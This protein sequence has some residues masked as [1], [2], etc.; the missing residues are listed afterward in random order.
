MDESKILAYA[1]SLINKRKYTENSEGDITVAM[2]ARTLRDA[3]KGDSG[4]FYTKLKRIARN[5]TGRTIGIEDPANKAFCFVSLINKTEYEGGVFTIEFSRYIQHYLKDF[6]GPYTWLQLLELLS[7]DSIYS[8]RIAEVLRS[9]LY[10]PK[11]GPKKT[12]WVIEFGVAEL[13]FLLGIANSEITAVRN[14]LNNSKTP[15]YDRA[16]QASPEKMYAQFSDMRRKCLEPSVREINEKSNME[17]AYDCV[18]AGHGGKVRAVRFFVRLRDGDVEFQ[19]QGGAKKLSENEKDRF[20][21]GILEL[22]PGIRFG[23]ARAIAEA[24]GYDFS[25]V[26]EKHAIMRTQSVNNPVG[27]MLEAINKDYKAPAPGKKRATPGRQRKHPYVDENGNP[28]TYD[29]LVRILMD[30]DAE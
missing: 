7:Y 25:V 3:L 29:D 13:K 26:E 17:V 14:I 15:D 28:C 18:R 8:F 9:R 27:W 16:L 5:M 4:G 24:S 6:S 1:L 2:R 19:G 10:S 12:E 21:D 11:N 30:G 22:M 20:L 23:E